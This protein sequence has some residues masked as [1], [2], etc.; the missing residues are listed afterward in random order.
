MRRVREVVLFCAAAFFAAPPALAQ[1]AKPVPTK[2]KP[3]KADKSSAAICPQGSY[4][5]DPAC[6]GANDPQALPTP[7]AR[8]SSNAARPGDILLEPKAGLNQGLQTDRGVIPYEG[9]NPDP[10]PRQSQF[11]G[12]LGLKLPF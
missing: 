11:G 6:F 8:S 10:N 1:D 9:N 2:A 5:G 7:S 4:K 12:G 3:A